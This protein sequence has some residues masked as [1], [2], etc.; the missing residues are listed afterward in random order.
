MIKQL[1]RFPEEPV[2]RP[3]AT[4]VCCAELPPQTK[5]ERDW[6]LRRG[7]KEPFICQRLSV[8]EIDGGTYCRLHGGHKVLDMYLK[9]RLK[10]ASPAVCRCAEPIW[11]TLANG[12]VQ[13]VHCTGY[14]EDRPP[15]PSAREERLFQALLDIAE[16][17]VKNAASGFPILGADVAR[18]MENR[19]QQEIDR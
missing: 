13:C 4:P 15:Q 12:K 17:R 7:Q 9:G 1:K 11:S 16:A 5:H 3:P 10:L 8:V 18:W 6:R 19:A 2:Y 14:K